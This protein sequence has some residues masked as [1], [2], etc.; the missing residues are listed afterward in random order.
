[1]AEIA[2]TVS[3]CSFWHAGDRCGAERIL[4]R[5]RFV[6][7]AA[8]RMDTGTFAVPQEVEESPATSGETC[9]DTFRPRPSHLGTHG[10]QAL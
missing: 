10:F 8:T 6:G 7:P 4:V 2:C 1:M 3:S 5:P 9:C